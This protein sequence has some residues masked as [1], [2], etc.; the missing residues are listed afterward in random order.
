MTE[1]TSHFQFEIQIGDAKLSFSGREDFLESFL[2]SRLESLLA[3]GCFSSAGQ[4]P[5]KTEQNGRQNSVVI[6]EGSVEASPEAISLDSFL[7]IHKA[8]T[9]PKRITGSLAWLSLE[10]RRSS[11]DAETLKVTIASSD[12]HLGRS[13]L[14]N[15]NRDLGRL[16]QKADVVRLADDRY[17]LSDEKLEEY[18]VAN[19]HS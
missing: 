4:V 7:S 3:L 18:R 2:D 17:R 9:C 12:Y 8:D 6:E 14:N 10:V 16:V 19:D 1:N 5:A 15:F 13:D 11:V